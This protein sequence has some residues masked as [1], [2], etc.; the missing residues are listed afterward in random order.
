[1]SQNDYSSQVIWDEINALSD[2]QKI[3][4]LLEKG[5]LTEDD[6]EDG[7]FKST[8]L[9]DWIYDLGLS[10]ETIELNY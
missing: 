10:A 7:F 9:T 6:I 5:V 4:V 3:Q 8:D 2:K 1:M